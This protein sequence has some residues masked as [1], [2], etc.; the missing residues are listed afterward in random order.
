MELTDRISKIVEKVIEKLIEQQVDINEM[1]FDFISGCGSTNAIFIL[2]QLLEEY[3][4][5]KRICTSPLYIWGKFLS[6]F[7]GRLFDEI[8]GN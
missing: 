6:E 5:K 1:K 7:L 2:K 8:K 3:L 4:A